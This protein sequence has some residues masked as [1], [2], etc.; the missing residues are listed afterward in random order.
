MGRGRS[1]AYLGYRAAVAHPLKRLAR[2]GTGE[3][4][5]LASYASEGLAPTTLEDHA[6]ADAASACLSCGLCESGCPLA[7]VAP[8]V[9][10]LGVH[11]ALRLYSKS[12]LALSVAGG[13]LEA[14]AACTGCEP[15]CPTGVPISRLVR[16]FA[17]RL[18]ES[19]QPL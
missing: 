17:A 2:K 16:Y 18:G 3:E 12:A 10:D 7:A 5:F 4:R 14:C 15:L 1:L 13:A 11:A 8:A 6:A 9:R 19:R